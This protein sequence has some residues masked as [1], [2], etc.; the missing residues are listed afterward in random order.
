MWVHCILLGMSVDH[1]QSLSPG[2][3]QAESSFFAAVRKVWA[4]SDEDTLDS[5]VIDL[6]RLVTG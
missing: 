4:G 2:Y 1:P 3:E 6:P 5:L